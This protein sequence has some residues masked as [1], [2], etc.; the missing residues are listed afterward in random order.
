MEEE[1]YSSSEEDDHDS[2][3]DTEFK[4]TPSKKSYSSQEIENILKSI[5]ESDGGKSA[6]GKDLSKEIIKFGAKK[7]SLEQSPPTSFKKL[8]KVNVGISQN[9]QKNDKTKEEKM[10]IGAIITISAAMVVLIGIL[11]YVL[12]S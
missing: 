10:I 5:S 12:L 3:E 8:P 2:D 11:A 7:E 9:N 4:K 1:T 6:R